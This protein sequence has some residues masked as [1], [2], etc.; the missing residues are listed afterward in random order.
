MKIYRL[1]ENITNVLYIVH[2]RCILEKTF[3][4]KYVIRYISKLIDLCESHNGIVVISDSDLFINKEVPQ[5]FQNLFDKLFSVADR[6]IF[7]PR[8]DKDNIGENVMTD[9]LDDLF[10]D[11]NSKVK[12]CVVGCFGG[13]CVDGTKANLEKQ[14]G[15]VTTIDEN[16]VENAGMIA[17]QEPETLK[18]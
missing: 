2:P 1:S 18:P 12:I 6:V 7:E 11:D 3:Y 14:Y 5:D 4:P 17:L 10:L 13:W 8:T 16:Y 15:K 9:V